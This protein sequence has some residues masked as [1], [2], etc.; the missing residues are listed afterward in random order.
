M[1]AL[2]GI[3]ALVFSALAFAGVANADP[4][5][6]QG[7]G[8]DKTPPGQS[9]T[10]VPPGQDDTFVPPGQVDDGTPGAS[11][12]K[13]WIC[14]A[15]TNHNGD[16]GLGDGTGGEFKAGYNL[17]Y[18]SQSAAEN[19]HF[20]LHPMDVP[21][22]MTTGSPVCPGTPVCTENC[23][24]TIAGSAGYSVPL[25]Y[26]GA[27]TTMNVGTQTATIDGTDQTAANN[28]AAAKWTDAS[29]A[30]ALSA[31]LVTN[32]AYTVVPASGVCTTPGTTPEAA[33]VAPAEPVTAVEA[34]TVTAPEP[35]KAAV[36][37]AATVAA[38]PPAA[39]PAGDGSSVPQTPVWALA[40]LALGTV[41]LAA[42]A[43]RL[44]AHSTT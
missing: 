17:I 4:G 8:Q 20:K 22:D 25:C 30:A 36:P 1:T 38:P 32:P 39:V 41:A 27:V 14:H 35:A 33:A 29:K 42:S 3:L 2:L 24:P 12:D 5:N 37:A 15:D 9:E 43:T 34:A 6:G 19:A 28:A 21:A 40:L 11:H 13:V 31:F 44:A 10:F 7:D 26:A 18:I 23:T 16:A